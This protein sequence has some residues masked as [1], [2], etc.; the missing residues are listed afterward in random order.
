[1]TYRTANQIAACTNLSVIEEME[2][3]KTPVPEQLQYGAKVWACVKEQQNFADAMFFKIQENWLN[4][5]PWLQAH[6]KK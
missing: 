1:M 2:K 5:E 4:P 3:N 6:P